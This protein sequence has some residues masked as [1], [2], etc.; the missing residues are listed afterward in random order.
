MLRLNCLVAACVSALTVGAANATTFDV[1][2]TASLPLGG[3]LDISSGAVGTADVTVPNPPNTLAPTAFTV[4][5]SS[6]AGV[7]GFWDITLNQGAT[8]FS[9]LL[10][11]PVSSLAGYAGGTI[12]DAE[13][14]PTSSGP[15]DITA[16]CEGGACGSLTAST[17]APPTT[18]LPAAL[19]LFATGLGALGLLARRRKRKVAAA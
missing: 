1:T 7:S 19:P 16:L 6:V 13:L 12:F 17:S 11:L 18:P 2:G 14:Y 10:I 9:L 3:T 4:L 5:T 8:G 15:E